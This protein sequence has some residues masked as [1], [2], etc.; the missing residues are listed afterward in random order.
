MNFAELR[1]WEYLASGLILILGARLVWSRIASST[2]ETFDKLALLLLGLSLLL[3]V[4]WVT[5][6]IFLTVAAVT[7]AGLLWIQKYHPQHATKCLVVL[8]PLQLAPLVYYKYANFIGNGLLNLN[9]DSLRHLLIPVGISF[10]TFQKVAFVVDTLVHKCPPPKFLDYM[11]FAGFFPQIVAGPIERRADLL[12][13]LERFRFRWL[14]EDI[15][16]G[17]SWMVVGFFFKCCLADN[18]ANNFS[19]EWPKNAYLVWLTNVIFGLRIYYDFAGYSLIALGVAQ[20]LGVKLTTNF[21]SPYCATNMVE[22]WRRWHVTLSQWFRDYLYV[23]LGGGRTRYW[24]FN[25][26]LV[27]VVSGIWHGAGVNFF[28][29]GALHA[30]FLIINRICKGFTPPKFFAWLLTMLASFFAWLCFYE[31][32]TK[33]LVAKIFLLLDP[34]EYGLDSLREALHAFLPATQFVLF[35]LFLLASATLLMEWFSVRRNEPYYYLR[36]PKVQIILV[37][38]TVWLAPIQNNGFIYFAF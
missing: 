24:A 23:P 26:T 3:C 6:L 37:V 28:L 14:P 29:W 19:T 12:P 9:I 16:R 30:L 25:V 17:F 13:Q 33:S 18:F 20:C 38:V 34:R 22:F 27:F 32:N 1:F 10:Y 21:L 15:N 7:Y 36:Q 4:S 5:F 11:N 8:I 2:L 35:S 31:T